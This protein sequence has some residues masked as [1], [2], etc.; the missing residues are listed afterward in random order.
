MAPSLPRLPH[1]VSKG[2]K[3]LPPASRIAFHLTCDKYQTHISKE[4]QLAASEMSL[5]EGNTYLQ[6][7]LLAKNDTPEVAELSLSA[8]WKLVQAIKQV[9]A[10]DEEHEVKLLAAFMADWLRVDAGDRNEVVR[11]WKNGKLTLLKS[12]RT[13][14][15]GVE[16]DQHIAIDDGIQIG[17]HDD[18]NTRKRYYLVD[19]RNKVEAAINSLPS[20][21]EPDA[22]ERFAEAERVLASSKRHLGDELHDQFSITLA[23]M[24]PEYVD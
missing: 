12:E 8:E 9:F 16:T 2:H 7:L 24:K 21:E 18:E 5:D 17:E 4:Q 23:D 22:T 19:A 15:A 14:D 6:N 11:E 1:S 3:T 13:S 20:P 10:P